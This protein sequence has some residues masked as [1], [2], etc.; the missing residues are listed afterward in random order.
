MS[1]LVSEQAI[2]DALHE[3]PRERWGEVLNF[4]RAKRAAAGPKQPDSTADLTPTALLASG[5]VGMWLDR[6]DI[7]DSLEFAQRL[8]VEAQTRSRE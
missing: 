6:S 5:L 4:L 7:G 1:A 8:R 2:L 3:V